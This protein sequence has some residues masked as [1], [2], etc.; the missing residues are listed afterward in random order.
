MFA[1]GVRI[2]TSDAH[3]IFDVSTGERINPA[4]DITIEPHVWLGLRSIILK[5][6]TIGADTVIGA[7][8]VV[9]KSIPAHSVAAGNPARVVRENVTWRIPLSD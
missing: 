5:G 2:M 8:A 6:V 7:Q 9:S 1:D 4:A 3:P